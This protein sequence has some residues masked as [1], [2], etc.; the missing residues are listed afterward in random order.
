MER[1]GEGWVC[2]E[3]Q[4]RR[5]EPKTP[6]NFIVKDMGSRSA[7]IFLADVDMLVFVCGTKPQELSYSVRLIREYD[8]N[9]AY[10][11]CP[12]VSEESRVAVDGILRSDYHKVLFLDYQPEPTDGAV[13]ARQFKIMVKKYMTGA[14]EH[15]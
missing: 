9:H 11:L 6:V 10:L 7:S 14:G 15:F 1:S 4:Y 12:F 13:N 8:V 3:V 5:Q 2:E